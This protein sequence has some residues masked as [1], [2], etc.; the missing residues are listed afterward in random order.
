MMTPDPVPVAKVSRQLGS[1]P[2]AFY[3]FSDGVTRYVKHPPDPAAVYCERLACALY[4]RLG[5]PVPETR[6]IPWGDAVALA[7]T[8]LEPAQT[9]N[10]PTPEQ[11]HD[12]LR[13]FAADVWLANRD[14]AGLGLINLLSHEG[15][16][17]RID[18]GGALLYR[19]RGLRKDL[20]D[21]PRLS[22]WHGFNN[23]RANLFYPRVFQ[24]AGVSNP[25]Q[26]PT[27]HA[28]VAAISTLVTSGELRDIISRE[29][30]GLSDDDKK[31]IHAML[32]VRQY[33]LN[34][35]MSGKVDALNLPNKLG[36]SSERTA[37]FLLN[38]LR[39][40]ASEFKQVPVCAGFGTSDEVYDPLFVVR[41]MTDH[42]ARAE[43]AAEVAEHLPE[44]V[45][46]YRGFRADPSDMA[47]I[48][49]R[50]LRCCWSPNLW[51]TRNYAAGWPFRNAWGHGAPL[52][53]T[54]RIKREHVYVWIDDCEV[55]LNPLELRDICFGPVRGN[56]SPFQRDFSDHVTGIHRVTFNPA[57]LEG[58]EIDYGRAL[59]RMSEAA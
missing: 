30:A 11:A 36:F 58:D 28:Q 40:S 7:S 1:N 41:A 19:A 15:Q 5:V 52:L 59:A 42:H 51:V 29:G 31:L 13:G 10:W 48:A 12:L 45:T 33:T 43:L 4:E 6:V 3:T 18:Q 32:V 44:D 22:E 57:C 37:S 23:L 21:L 17:Y 16:V 26:I 35:I 39:A 46:V 50:L 2:G 38:L 27:I 49:S 14:V 9:V 8:R 53:A 25:L 56:V 24:A 20:R 34:R 55:F 54:A 47:G